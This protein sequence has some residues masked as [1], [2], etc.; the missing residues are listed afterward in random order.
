MFYSQLNTVYGIKHYIFMNISHSQ[1]II[2]D[3]IIR[4]F[5]RASRASASAT[6]FPVA[7]R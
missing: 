1:E 5:R 3:F 2:I 4:Q 7:A 6:A